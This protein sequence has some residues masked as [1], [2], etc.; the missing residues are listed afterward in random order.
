MGTYA[1]AAAQ[2]S[3]RLAAD[4]AWV[5]WGMAAAVTGMLAWLA[6]FALIP[7]DAK[8]DNGEKHLVQVL[9]EHTGQLYA[10]AAAA[11]GVLRRAHP[12]GPRRLPRL[13]FAPRVPGRVRDHRDHGGHRRIVR[14]GWPARRG[15]ERR[16]GWP[17][18]AGARS[19]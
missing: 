9:R 8:L 7:L 19:G 1:G 12:P 18:W 15:R 13:G 10:A 17:R 6:G 2:D 5:R 11:G 14:A 3:E 16:W 4:R